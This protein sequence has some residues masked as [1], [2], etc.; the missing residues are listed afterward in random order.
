MAENLLNMNE[1]GS[2]AISLLFFSGG[3]PSDRAEGLAEKMG[4]IAS[5]FGHH[6]TVCCVGM[7]GQKEDFSML[8]AMVKEAE[9]CGA[10]ASFS[11]PAV[12]AGSL[13]RMILTHVSSLTST[14]TELTDLATGKS[15]TVRDRHYS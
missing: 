7:A 12:P 5:R 9:A 4:E 8:E 6:L 15:R 3:K 1:H 13:S 2:C 10:V 14:K 11:K